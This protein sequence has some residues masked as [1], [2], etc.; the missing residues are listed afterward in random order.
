MAE[1]TDRRA[2]LVQ[3]LSDIGYDSAE[4]EFL[5]ERDAQALLQSLTQRRRSLLNGVHR[6]QK[7]IDCL[8]YLVYRLRREDL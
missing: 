5:L 2:M 4:I 6:A 3:C 7:R 1:A 8:D